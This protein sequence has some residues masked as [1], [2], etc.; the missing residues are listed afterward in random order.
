MDNKQTVHHITLN[1]SVSARIHTAT[2]IPVMLPDQILEKPSIKKHYGNKII[3]GYP[4]KLIEFEKNNVIE[5]TEIIQSI[6]PYVSFDIIRNHIELLE[7]IKFSLSDNTI[8]WI[9]SHT[10]VESFL[11]MLDRHYQKIGC[12]EINEYAGDTFDQLNKLLEKSVEVPAPKRWRM[13]EF[14]DHI[15]EL[16]LE[17]TTNNVP[18]ET[19]IEPK[20]IDGYTIWQPKESLDLVFWGRKVKNC[21]ASYEERIGDSIWIFFIEKNEQSFYTV[22]TDKKFNIKQIVT[23][24]NG[25]VNVEQ[26]NLVHDLILKAVQ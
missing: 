20:T 22:E 21:V 25:S 3:S 19:L 18:I 2:N 13:V 17:H 4:E 11:H 8:D 12:I 24:C 26:Q 9:R 23:Q 15:S 6:W 5:N 1:S 10:K 14:H 7:I 16:Y